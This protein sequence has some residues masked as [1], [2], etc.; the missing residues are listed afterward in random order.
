MPRACERQSCVCP[1]LYCRR[2]H[3]KQ[4]EFYSLLP[5][6]KANF[7]L[8]SRHWDSEKIQTCCLSSRK[9]TSSQEQL[10]KSTMSAN[11][12]C[13]LWM[14]WL[15]LR[16]W[17]SASPCL[18]VEVWGILP[19]WGGI[20]LVAEVISLGK[21]GAKGLLTGF[22]PNPGYTW[23]IPGEAFKKYSCPRLPW[24]AK[25]ESLGVWPRD[26]YF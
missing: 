2:Q 17:K 26:Q 24:P 20:R 13:T 3:R 4:K 18:G 6:P 11:V 21:Q 10:M 8:F 7:I 5:K 1:L 22:Q 23:E 19:S 14:K 9:F 25:S 15:I 12:V 16:R